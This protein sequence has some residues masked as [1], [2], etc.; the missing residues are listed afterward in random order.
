M[1]N[2]LLL[3]A[4]LSIFACQ[5][6][7]SKDQSTVAESNQTK[8]K[9]LPAL[10]TKALKAHGGL[11]QWNEMQTMEFAFPKGDTKEHQ[12]IDLKNRKVLLTHDDYKVG[13]DGKDVWVSPNK[14]AFGKRSARFY[15]NLIF[16]FYAMPFVLADDGII[17]E[18]LP[19]R[20]FKGEAYAALKISYHD[21]VGD[22]PDDYYI[23][24]FDKSSG[25][26][27]YLLYTVTYYSKE[28]SEK[29]SALHY[30]DWENVNGLTLPKKMVGYKF[31]NEQL[32]EMRYERIFSDAKLSK[33]AKPANFFAK[34][35]GSEIS[36]LE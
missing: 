34:P 28:K 27:E 3:G 10:L 35:E 6:S 14:E 17:Y 4:L 25:L 30:S 24:H 2:L 9:D 12:L 36:P 23:A 18:Q 7:Q 8:T 26:M 29:F 33:D 15:H 32:G 31:E 11:E 16:Y 19:D 22:A 20:T 13:F 21:G 5:Q 1:K